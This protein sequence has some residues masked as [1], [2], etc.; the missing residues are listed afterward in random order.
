MAVR[1]SALSSRKPG[2]FTPTPQKAAIR[3]Y[4]RAREWERKPASPASTV[5]LSAGL[6]WRC[7]NAR[8][9]MT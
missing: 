6:D 5:A 2:Q 4:H 1:C 3:L 8:F 7:W 9:S